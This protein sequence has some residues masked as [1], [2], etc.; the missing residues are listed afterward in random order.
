MQ[1]LYNAVRGQNA[2]NLV[3]IGGDNY[4]YDLSGVSA[5]PI[6][7][8]VNVAYVTHPH[9]FKQS[10][11]SFQ[12]AFLT[13]AA[14]LPVVATEFGNAGIN[15]GTVA[16]N[17]ADYSGPLGNFRTA[18]SPSVG[19]GSD[20]PRRSRDQRSS[21]TTPLGRLEAVGSTLDPT[22]RDSAG[23]RPQETDTTQTIPM[24]RMG[25]GSTAT[26]AR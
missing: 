5:N 21:G 23:S 4:A 8:A 9:V 25:T 11:K 16:C 17:L 13:P 18:G 3:L 24:F 6:T 12:E 19:P 26:R 22:R 2:N 15:G 14:T 1:T 20:G 7:G 10:E